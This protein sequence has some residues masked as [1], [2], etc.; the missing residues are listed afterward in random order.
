MGANLL[1]N[2]RELKPYGFY[3]ITGSVVQVKNSDFAGYTQQV[4]EIAGIGD[5]KNQVCQP[6]SLDCYSTPLPGSDEMIVGS[7]HHRDK[8]IDSGLS[9]TGE[10]AKILTGINR[11]LINIHQHQNQNN[12]GKVEN[13][14]LRASTNESLQLSLETQEQL[15][16]LA[17]NFK[18]LDNERNAR[19]EEL[20][21]TNQSVA[22]FSA[23]SFVQSSDTGLEIHKMVSGVRVANRDRLPML[24]KIL[25]RTTLT[26]TCKTLTHKKYQINLLAKIQLPTK[27]TDIKTESSPVYLSPQGVRSS[28]FLNPEFHPD[29][30]FFSALGSRGLT[31]APLLAYHLICTYILGFSSPI[32]DGLIQRSHPQRQFIKEVIRGTNRI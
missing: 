14:N 18:F 23:Q 13:P 1:H 26:T 3:P 10:V 9:P 8:F 17:H 31:T 24:G 15:D 7:T 11:D 16:N 4:M 28:D 30:I 29:D 20:R 21:P 12:L 27:N 19:E 25:D 6:Y 2:R 22:Q 5:N 32:A